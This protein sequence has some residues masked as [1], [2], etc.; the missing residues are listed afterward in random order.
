MFHTSNATIINNTITVTGAGFL[1]CECW[2]TAG[3]Y[4]EGGGSNIVTENNL[5]NNDNAIYFD[6]TENNLIVG[7]NITNT[8]SRGWKQFWN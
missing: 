7:N 2:E 5:V 8:L 6:H 3:I 1:N 4:V